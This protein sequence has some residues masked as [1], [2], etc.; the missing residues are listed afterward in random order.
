MLAK[1][2]GGGV[3]TPTVTQ[4]GIASWAD[5]CAGKRTPGVYS[6]IS[7]LV[8]WISNVACD[9]TGELC[10]TINNGSRKANIR[11]LK[12]ERNN[13]NGECVKVPVYV[14][15]GPFQPSLCV[16]VDEEPEEGEFPL[17]NLIMLA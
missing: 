6:R 11:H 14:P 5:R 16:A 12:R 10:E 3:E 13:D 4:V 2:L 8:H 1:G 17:L 15:P 7:S 9:Q